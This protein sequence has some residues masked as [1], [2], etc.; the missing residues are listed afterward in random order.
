[1]LHTPDLPIF[2][3]VHLFTTLNNLNNDDANY[4]FITAHSSY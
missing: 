2:H 1:M 4:D 3:C